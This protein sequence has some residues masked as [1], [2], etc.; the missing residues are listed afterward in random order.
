[1]EENPAN[2]PQK[3]RKPIGPVT[4]DTLEQKQFEEK[5]LNSGDES[6]YLSEESLGN[7]YS[8]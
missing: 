3:S 8:Y 2:L 4:K 7:I 5:H 1:M 6:N